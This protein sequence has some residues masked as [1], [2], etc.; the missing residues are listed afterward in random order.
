MI[1]QAT[2]VVQGVVGLL[3]LASLLSWTILIGKSV[4][5][6]IKGRAIRR[7]KHMLGQARTLL[8]AMR[9]KDA[10]SN[11][12]VLEAR[13]EVSQSADMVQAG[14]I[15]GLQERTS[16]RLQRIEDA[17]ERRASLGLNLLASIGSV[18]PFIGLFGTV[19]GI[20]GSFIGIAAANTTSLA[21]VAPGIAEALLATALGLVAAIPATLM[22]NAFGKSIGSYRAEIDDVVSTILC[23]VGRDAEREQLAPPLAARSA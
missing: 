16:A 6:S 13:D 18:T 8:D 7:A 19:W 23:L 17:A 15:Y 22:Y 10:L 12:L 1:Q 14:M 20:M 21:V 5:L 3:A 4:E 2:P 11:R 9:V